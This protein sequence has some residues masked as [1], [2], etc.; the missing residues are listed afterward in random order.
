MLRM[1][2]LVEWSVWKAL[3]WQMASTSMA[4]DLVCGKAWLWVGLLVRG[5]GDC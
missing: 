5:M 1:D 4:R 3:V 2:P